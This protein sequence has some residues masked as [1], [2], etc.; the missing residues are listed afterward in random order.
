MITYVIL[1][2]FLGATD[3]RHESGPWEVIF[4]IK[5]ADGTFSAP[6][7]IA[8]YTAGF[9]FKKYLERGETVL[10]N[11]RGG[12]NLISKTDHILSIWNQK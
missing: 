6:K 2:R 8:D 9:T 12:W 10:V 11:P 1:S 4:P 5:N 7:N 3:Q